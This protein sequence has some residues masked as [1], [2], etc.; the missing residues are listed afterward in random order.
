[1]YTML[2]QADGTFSLVLW[3]IQHKIEIDSLL[4]SNLCYSNNIIYINSSTQHDSQLQL[5]SIDGKTTNS[6]T[7]RLI[8]PSFFFFHYRQRNTDRIENFVIQMNKKLH[9]STRINYD[10]DECDEMKISIMS[11]VGSP[12][13]W[14]PERWLKMRCKVSR[15]KRS[16]RQSTRRQWPEFGW[17]MSRAWARHHLE[18]RRTIPSLWL[19]VSGL[20]WPVSPPSVDFAS[21]VRLSLKCIES[22]SNVKTG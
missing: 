20:W 16:R 1:M 5:A 21:K 14:H 4:Y 6:S 12:A 8:L 3:M 9:K 17:R 22:E 13:F 10:D 2:K 19:K 15:T 18:M 7:K 11:Y